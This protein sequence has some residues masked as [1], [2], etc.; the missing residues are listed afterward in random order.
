MRGGGEY[1]LATVTPLPSPKEGH[2]LEIPRGKEVS[3]TLRR[4][5]QGG[6]ACPL[7]EFEILSCRNFGRSLHRCR[8]FVH[9][10]ARS[11]LEELLMYFWYV[12]LDP[13]SGGFYCKTHF[14]FPKQFKAAGHRN[15]AVVYSYCEKGCWKKTQSVRDSPKR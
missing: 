15:D 2:K 14:N 12:P 6:H 7:S 10:H 11:S 9:C 1:S 5:C 4:A 3:N 13:H 8:N